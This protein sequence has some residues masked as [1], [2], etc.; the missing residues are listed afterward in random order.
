ME[1]NKPNI[2][3]Y[4]SVFGNNPEINLEEKNRV[5]TELKKIGRPTFKVEKFEDGWTATCLEIPGLI[6]ANS[7]PNPSDFEIESQ[8]RE[9]IYSA[10]NVKFE[11]V[12]TPAQFELSMAC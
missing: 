10:Y 5:N 12:S 7:N 4:A 1:K 6:A 3:R 2:N 9:A 8:V 11:K